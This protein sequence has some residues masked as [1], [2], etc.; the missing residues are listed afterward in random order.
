MINF[1]TV[2]QVKIYS[3]RN[4]TWSLPS[5]VLHSGWHMGVVG[6]VIPDT[7][8]TRVKRAIKGML[9]VMKLRDLDTLGDL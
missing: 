1:W 8:I 6:R 5:V 4:K 9:R 7:T 3:V 2:C